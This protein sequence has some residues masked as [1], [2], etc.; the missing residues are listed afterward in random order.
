MNTSGGQV[1]LYATTLLHTCQP[2]HLDRA[3]ETIAPHL[4]EFVSGGFHGFH[5]TPLSHESTA[6]YVATY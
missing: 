3:S 1:L 2:V 6:D 4:V 5:G